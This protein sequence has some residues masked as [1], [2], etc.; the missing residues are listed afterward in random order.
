MAAAIHLAYP[1]DVLETIRAR[2]GDL[3]AVLPRPSLLALALA[4][5]DVAA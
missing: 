2:T 5:G 3:T 1:V 4:S